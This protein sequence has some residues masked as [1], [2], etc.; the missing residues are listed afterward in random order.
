VFVAITGTPLAAQERAAHRA[1]EGGL[2]PAPE[3]LSPRTR[4]LGRSIERL[5]EDISRTNRWMIVNG[6]PE[7]LH[8]IGTELAHAGE[9]LQELVRRLDEAYTDTEGE[10]SRKREQVDA[11][12]AHVRELE[13]EMA[14]TLAALRRA[15][16][17][18]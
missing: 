5:V 1:H 6:A 2:S 11:L 4:E 10:G 9:H 17:Y 3:T 16:G 12:S 13:R 15:V 8:G 18:R 7:G 14:R